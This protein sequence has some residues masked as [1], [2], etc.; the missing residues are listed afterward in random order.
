MHK[1][2]S[3][4]EETVIQDLTSILAE[5]EQVL[6]KLGLTI[7]LNDLRRSSD[8]GSDKYQS[9]VAVYF[10]DENGVFDVL[11][12]FIFQQGTRVATL[13]ETTDWIREVMT[14]VQ[15]RRREYLEQNRKGAENRKGAGP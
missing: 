12:F 10:N 9:E 14:E 11:E 4:I 5:H 15:K 6:S 2:L 13:K 3:M 7:Q 8:P 1:E